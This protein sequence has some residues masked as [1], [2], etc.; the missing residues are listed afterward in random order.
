MEKIIS[1]NPW[2]IL[3]L[4]IWMI[5]WKGWALWKSA[6]H[7]QH[8]WF[9]VLLIINSLAILEILYIFFFSRDE[10]K[11]NE[12]SKELKKEE[13]KTPVRHNLRKPRMNIVR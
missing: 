3:I 9:V 11:K 12:V 5:P 13:G 2:I 6:R 10:I 7:G 8:A 1:E 4:A